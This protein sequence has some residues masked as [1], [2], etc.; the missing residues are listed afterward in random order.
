[1]KSLVESLLHAFH[2]AY[3][4]NPAAAYA[5]LLAVLALRRTGRRL[6]ALCAAWM[7]LAYLP[8]LMVRGYADRFSYVSALG[9]VVLLSAA[10]RAVWERNRYAGTAVALALLCFF[11]IGMQHRITVWNEAG[12]IARQ[13]VD[14]VASA[15]PELP[16][17]ATLVLL[18]VPDMHAHALVFMT[19]LE[20]AVRLRYAPHEA[21]SVTREM[22]ADAPAAVVAFRYEAGHMRELSALDNATPPRQPAEASGGSGR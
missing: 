15:R 12:A 13:V 19:G 10:A 2:G 22:P 18:D 9:A 1:V 21:F 3:R 5:V 20:R 14:D 11:G 6:M 7:L 8:F 16:R 17:D 4:A